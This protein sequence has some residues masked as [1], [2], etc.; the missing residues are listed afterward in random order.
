MQVK[1][2]GSVDMCI[3]AVQLFVYKDGFELGAV[4]LG[5]VS[6]HISLRTMGFLYLQFVDRCFLKSG[7]DNFPK[8]LF[9]L[10]CRQH[11]GWGSRARIYSAC[12]TLP[13]T[14]LPTS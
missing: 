8:P 4:F 11:A 13:F 14:W 9:V 12:S 10:P 7:M 5:M 3:L 6:A 1:Y 2:L